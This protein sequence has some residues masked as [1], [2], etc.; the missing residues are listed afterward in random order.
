MLKYQS[1]S[2]ISPRLAVQNKIILPVDLVSF[3]TCFLKLYL[4][5]VDIVSNKK[6]TSVCVN[7]H[8]QQIGSK[9]KDFWRDLKPK[10][11]DIGF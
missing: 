11:Q 2:L 3:K 8:I 5:S 7:R 1:W 10:I 9:T 6:T 4:K